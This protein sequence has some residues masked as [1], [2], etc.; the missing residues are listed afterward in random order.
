MFCNG[1]IPAVAFYQR[2]HQS[3]RLT[4]NPKPGQVG[5]H[6]WMYAGRIHTHTH[7]P[8]QADKNL[9]TLP[10]AGVKKQI[11]AWAWSRDSAHCGM[12]HFGWREGNRKTRG[13]NAETVKKRKN[14]AKAWREDVARINLSVDMLTAGLRNTGG[15]GKWRWSK[16]LAEA[17]VRVSSPWFTTL[18]GS[19]SIYWA[20]LWLFSAFTKNQSRLLSP[21]SFLF[22]PFTS[23][24]IL[25]VLAANPRYGSPAMSPFME[26]SFL[27]IR[28]RWEVSVCCLCVWM[29][30]ISHQV[31][32]S[33]FCC[34]VR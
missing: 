12:L 29:W 22:R 7:T 25:S 30:G 31:N 1:F 8:Q 10:T 17:A 3:T 11:K 18:F 24:D 15:H 21:W 26:V 32:P 14:E 20:S 9:D 28:S 23:S 34:K 16:L 13:G 6:T 2:E 27:V 19:V 4:F 5:G 33:R